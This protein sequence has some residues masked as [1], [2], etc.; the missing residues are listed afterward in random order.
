MGTPRGALVTRKG[1]RGS[2]RAE[3]A[4]DRADGKGPGAKGNKEPRGNSA[5]LFVRASPEDFSVL[6]L[7]RTESGQDGAFIGFE[8]KVPNLLA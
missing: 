6:R 8:N 7:N 2:V 5:R 1:L 4:L 3:S